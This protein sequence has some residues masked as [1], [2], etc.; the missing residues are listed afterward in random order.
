MLRTYEGKA[1][2]ATIVA[3]MLF[4]WLL[5]LIKHNDLAVWKYLF[6]TVWGSVAVSSSAIFIT[7][8]GVCMLT[9]VLTV[10]Y[11]D[12]RVLLRGILCTI[13]AFVVL[14]A[15]VM[16]RIGVLRIPI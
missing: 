3:G 8:L 6:V 16:N 1:I 5:C 11:R 9:V 14:G 4:Y 2:S 12:S 15:Y 10:K 13:P 7:V